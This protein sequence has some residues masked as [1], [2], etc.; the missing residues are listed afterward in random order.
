[1]N[2]TRPAQIVLHL[3]PDTVACLRDVLSRTANAPYG[4]L[5]VESAGRPG[6]IH[7]RHGLFKYTLLLTDDGQRR[8]FADGCAQ[9]DARAYDLMHEEAMSLALMRVCAPR[10]TWVHLI[11]L[12]SYKAERAKRAGNLDR[13]RWLQNHIGSMKQVRRK[14]ALERE[15]FR[16]TVH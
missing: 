13:A 15:A 16:P 14:Y 11:Q 4:I 10:V 9:H 2:H 7:R 1:M 5:A 3:P 8:L 6:A 12:L